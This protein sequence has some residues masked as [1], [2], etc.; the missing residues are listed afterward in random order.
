MALFRNGSLYL[1]TLRFLS[2]LRMN[3]N[4]WNYVPHDMKFYNGEGT[5]NRHPLL[6]SSWMEYWRGFTETYQDYV[7]C[8]VCGCK[9]TSS[10]TDKE[11]ENHNALN[12]RGV[13]R[14]AC[15]AHVEI[16]VGS[17]LYYIAPMCNEC[18]FEGKMVVIKSGTKLVPEIAP[19]IK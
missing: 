4:T 12:T 8:C 3:K 11:I 9:I 19:I 17:E 2:A 16:E 5:S 10:M 13:I 15:G 6:F 14:R 7:K 18:N 1:K